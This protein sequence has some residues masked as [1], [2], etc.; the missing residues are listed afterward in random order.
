MRSN[1]IGQYCETSLRNWAGINS[2]RI[3]CGLMDCDTTQ[4]CGQPN[5]FRRNIL[6]PSSRW[7][8]HTIQASIF[9]VATSHNSEWNWNLWSHSNILSAV[10]NYRALSALVLKNGD[11]SADMEHKGKQSASCVSAGQC[12]CKRAIW[13]STDT[14]GVKGKRRKLATLSK[15]Q[16]IDILR[17]PSINC[18]NYSN[19]DL[20]FIYHMTL[21][22]MPKWV[23]KNQYQF[24]G[25]YL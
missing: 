22:C 25:N 8:L 11:K 6:L 10:Y 14:N 18:Q 16:A 13:L 5:T 15:R 4:T 1:E 3:G 2:L 21:H 17:L 19:T 9:K 12:Y 7:R 23:S 20:I 24:Q